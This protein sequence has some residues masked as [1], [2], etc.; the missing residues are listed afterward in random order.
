[1]QYKKNQ[2][3]VGMMIQRCHK[4]RQKRKQC[5]DNARTAGDIVDRERL[6]QSGEHYA[7]IISNEQCKIDSSKTDSAR[8]VKGKNPKQNIETS[9]EEEEDSDFPDFITNT[10]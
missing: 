1:M 5:L 7:R 3:S 4:W 2:A 10:K 6:L 8:D 9:N